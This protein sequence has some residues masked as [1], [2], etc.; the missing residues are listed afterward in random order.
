MSVVSISPSKPA[1]R[2]V[3]YATIEDRI[4]IVALLRDA[5]AAATSMPVPFSEPHAMALVDRHI[6]DS[7]LLALVLGNDPVGVLL[8]SVQDHPYGGAQYA[9]EAAWWIAPD[10]R[11]RSAMAMLDAYEQWAVE[12]ECAFCQVAALVSFPQAARLY[13][14]RGYRPVET[15]FMKVF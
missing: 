15:H 3:R 5:H 9:L 6:A 11:G 7:N 1:S 14:R 4:A 2:E 8:A 13:E 12:R 10:V